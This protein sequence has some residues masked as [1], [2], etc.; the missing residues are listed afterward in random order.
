[1]AVSPQVARLQRRIEAIPQE[2]RKAVLPALERSGE[3]LADTMRTLAP[4]DEGDLKASIAVTLPGESTPA[5][6]QPGGARIAGE[7]EVL[8]TAGN[9][10]VRYP[11]LQ[12]YGT[13]RHDA[14]PFFWPA[15]RLLQ[16]KVKNR[17]KRAVAKAVRDYWRRT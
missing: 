12:E 13:A 5:Y 10:E 2:V 14:Q 7:L 6:S 8:V 4:E 16:K 9:S 1:M 15:V 17:T 3:E 11:H